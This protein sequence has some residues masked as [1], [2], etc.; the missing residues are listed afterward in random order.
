[1]AAHSSILAWKIPWKENPGWLQS[2]GLQRYNLTSKQQQQLQDHTLVQQNTTL[3]VKK[4]LLEHS[5]PII[6]IIFVA[7]L[8]RQCQSC[9]SLT[10]AD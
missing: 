8:A 4:I 1:M 10:Q 2:T 3:F 7:A 6:Y 9:I 5:I